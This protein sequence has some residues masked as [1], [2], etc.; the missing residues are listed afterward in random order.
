MTKPT[1]TKKPDGT[2]SFELTLDA[3]V[4]AAEYQKVLAEVAKTAAIKGFRPGKAPLAMVESQTDKSKLYSHVLDHLLS[5]AYSDVINDNKLVPLVEPRVTPKS[6]EEGKDWVMAVE[7]AMAPEIDLGDYEKYVKT[8][9][10][11]HEK[12][13]KHAESKEKAKPEEEKEHKLN[14]IFDALLDNAKVEVSPIL[15]DEETKSALSR[16]ASQLQSLKLSVEDYAKSVKKTTDELVTE[17]KKSAEA[18]LKLE[19]ILQKLIELRKPEVSDEEIATLK[20][21]K[22]QEGYAKYVLKKRK[23]LDF[24]SGL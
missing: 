3:K 11:K 10:T 2:I 6:M 5:P 24:F 14:V 12:E 4:I 20:P 22:G 16:L 21:Q 8:S 17:Y 9:L 23:L 15:I 1:L 13:H 18:N 19:F 7:V